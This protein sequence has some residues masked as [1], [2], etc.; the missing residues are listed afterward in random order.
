[1]AGKSKPTADDLVAEALKSVER[2]EKERKGQPDE[3]DDDIDLDAVEV[4][5]PKDTPPSASDDGDAPDADDSEEE[6]IIEDD[7]AGAG[8]SGGGA[9]ASGKGDKKSDPIL[10]MMIAAKNEAV[11]AL[12]QTQKEAKSLQERLQRVSADFENYKKRQN[13]EKEEAI[14]FANEKLLK[15]LM[16]ILDNMARATIA[17]QQAVDNAQ[18][19]AAKTILDGT[20][21][22]L[23]QFE[24]SLGRFGIR[25]FEAMGK[26]FDPALHEAVGAREDASVPNQTV[27]EEYQRGYMLHD[28]LA[29]PA[30]VVVSSGGPAKGTAPKSEGAENTEETEESGN[31]EG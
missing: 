15:E 28:R 10:E 3:D 8:Q 12:A 14:R 18:E 26:P 5:P 4:L 31:T 6:I 16:P 17:G 22:V 29:R 30:M 21:M 11:D 2:I 13:R 19:G 25:A 23:K 20:A 9:T 7:D 27:I 24:E 1:M